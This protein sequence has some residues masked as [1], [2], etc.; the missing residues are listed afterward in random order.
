MKKILAVVVAVIM[1]CTLS[2]S[3]FAE[4]LFTLTE[5]SSGDGG[6]TI[7]D[8]YTLTGWCPS[9][10]TE[11]QFPDVMTAFKEAIQTE[12]AKIE[13]ITSGPINGILLQ[14]YPLD[15][16]SSY[17][18]IIYNEFTSSEADGRTVS[19]FDAAG[20]VSTYTSTPHGD[21]ATVTLSMDNVLNFAV[22]ASEGTVLYGV[23][24]YTDDA[25]E[26]TPAES[27][28]TT[29]ET[30]TTTD[31]TT[32]TTEPETPAETPAETGIVLAVLPMAVAAAAVVISKKK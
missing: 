18:H 32:T 27:T 4:D 7:A 24:V 23:R 8:G 22:D 28:D 20:F 6:V 26:E 16:G 29:A 15:G 13:V 12:G 2:L 1:A 19:V 25:A 14:S 21:D 17:T 10:I 31:D 30:D 11:Y 3:V 5:L 9:L